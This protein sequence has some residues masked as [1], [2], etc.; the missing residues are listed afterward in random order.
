MA[1]GKSGHGP[2]CRRN[3]RTLAA[4][5]PVPVRLGGGF[6]AWRIAR[7]PQ[8]VGNIGIRNRE[9]S[10]INYDQRRLSEPTPEPSAQLQLVEAHRRR[11]EHLEE[12]LAL[13]CVEPR[14]P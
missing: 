11:D 12:P 3:G 4:I 13:R 2:L 14:L 6:A 9:A 1:S 7:R 10:R 5:D 8:K